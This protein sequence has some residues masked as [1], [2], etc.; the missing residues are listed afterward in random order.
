MNGITRNVSYHGLANQNVNMFCLVRGCMLR[1]HSILSLFM[2]RGIPFF[3]GGG[4]QA[5]CLVGSRLEYS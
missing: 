4:G 3:A 2:R 1:I 5:A